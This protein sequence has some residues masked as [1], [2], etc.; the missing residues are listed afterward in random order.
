MRKHLSCGLERTKGVSH[1]R[2]QA[3]TLEF[4][5]KRKGVQSFRLRAHRPSSTEATRQPSRGRPRAGSVEMS[6][7]VPAFPWWL[8]DECLQCRRPRFDHWIGK[9][10][11]RRPWQPTPV[12]LPGESHGQRSLAGHSLQGR[13]E[14]TQVSNQ[15]FLSYL[16]ISAQHAQPENGKRSRLFTGGE[17]H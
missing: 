14:W 13:K 4:P 2:A 3:S 15:H 12:F 7:Q 8:C 11:W 17:D 10:P 1:A 9:M 6:G 16:Q 5:S